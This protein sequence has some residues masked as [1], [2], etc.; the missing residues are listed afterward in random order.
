MKRQ[1][2]R[3]ENGKEGV[4]ERRRLDLRSSGQQKGMRLNYEGSFTKIDKKISEPQ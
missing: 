1:E 3:M 2:S 4:W